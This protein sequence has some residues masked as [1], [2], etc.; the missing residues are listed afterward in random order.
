MNKKNKNKSMWVLEPHGK[1]RKLSGDRANTGNPKVNRCC[2]SLTVNRHSA[3]CVEITLGPSVQHNL[4]WVYMNFTLFIELWYITC[5]GFVNFHYIQE[6]YTYQ[7]I[8]IYN[9]LSHNIYASFKS[10]V[11]EFQTYEQLQLLL[12]SWFHRCHH[13]LKQVSYVRNK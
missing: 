3:N 1:H 11:C 12:L 4:L 2:P 10:T 8:R 13:E 9:I 7:Q 6:R 5:V